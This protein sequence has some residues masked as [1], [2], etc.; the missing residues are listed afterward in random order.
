MS[1][2]ELN[3]IMI[4]AARIGALGIIKAA[5]KAGADVNAR[6]DDETSVTPL[7]AAVN[8]GQTHTVKF[9]LEHGADAKSMYWGGRSLLYWAAQFG[10]VKIAKML[11]EH[12]VDI[13]VREMDDDTF[14]LSAL[15]VAAAAGHVDF[16][17]FL[18]D[19]GADVN[20]KDKFGEIPLRYAESNGNKKIAKLLIKRGAEP[21][22][23]DC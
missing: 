19:N 16:V 15:H 11:L 13:N 10:R 22:S 2:K 18:L 23:T 17:K 12:G 20:I 1:N 9:L 4:S 8:E 14:R 5:L 6:E 3:N 21:D 7:L